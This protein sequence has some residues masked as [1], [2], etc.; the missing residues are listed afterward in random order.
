MPRRSGGP[1]GNSHDRKI[2][3]DKRTECGGPEDRHGERLCLPIVPVL[4]TSE[5]QTDRIPN[6]PVRAIS[7]RAYRP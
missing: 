1:K 3:V 5:S 7:Y 4:R 6:R 2:V